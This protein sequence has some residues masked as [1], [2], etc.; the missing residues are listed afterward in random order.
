MSATMASAESSFVSLKA[1]LD[2]LSYSEPLGV[3]SAPLVARLLADLILTTESYELLRARCEH[4]ERSAA[5]AHEQAAP[6]RKEN[7]RLIRENNEVGVVW[8]GPGACAAQCGCILH[9]FTVTWRVLRAALG[10][11]TVGGAA[12]Y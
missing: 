1:Q 7:S 8:R 12:G 9:E 6:M 4:A 5:V 2:A 10:S 3:E 11:M